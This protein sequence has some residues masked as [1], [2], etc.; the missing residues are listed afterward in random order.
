[1]TNASDL[2]LYGEPLLMRAGL[3]NMLFPWARCV[4][5]CH[6]TGAEMIAPRWR[7]FRIGPYGRREPDKRQYQR[8]FLDEGYV[9]GL[10]RAW[11]EVSAHRIDEAQ[12]N[13]RTEERNTVVQFKGLGD[14]FR[15]L[16]GHADEVKAELIRITR[17]HLIPKD[18]G[19]PFVGVHI[20]LGDFP[21]TWRRPLQWYVQVVRGL[22]A[23]LGGKVPIVV[24]SDGSA[25]EIRPVLSL[26]G[27]HRSIGGTAITDL[28]Q[29]ARASCIV[30]SH[31][32]FSLWGAYL[33][34]IPTIRF[35][36][37]ETLDALFDPQREIEWDGRGQL[38]PAFLHEIRESLVP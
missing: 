14:Y 31:S 19:G 18:I 20:R 28:L 25:D 7:K 6:A 27:V 5:W 4:T 16:R 36:G 24:F 38:P 2:G 32:T 34:S 30:A 26:G 21:A 12:V 1:M 11:L 15:S 9:R 22:W 37:R 35:P 10:R 33:G 17:P 29:L 13:E 23:A 3:G 8:L